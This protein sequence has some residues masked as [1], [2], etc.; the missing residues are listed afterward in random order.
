MFH[1][2]VP[3]YHRSSQ[4]VHNVLLYRGLNTTF[5]STM[6][7]ILSLVHSYLLAKH[8]MALGAVILGSLSVGNIV[9]DTRPCLLLP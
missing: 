2:F 9:E 5:Y 1:I 8:V 6:L 3:N 4:S 7:N